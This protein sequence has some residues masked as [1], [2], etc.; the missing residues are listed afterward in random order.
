MPERINVPGIRCIL[1]FILSHG[2]I[3]G[4]RDQDGGTAGLDAVTLVQILCQL[5]GIGIQKVVD[6]FVV[7]GVHLGLL[8]L[9]DG[10]RLVHHRPILCCSAALHVVAI[11][12]LAISDY[13]CCG[14]AWVL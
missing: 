3:A 7:Y 9:G 14:L 5:A 4:A 2:E 10:G 13:S 6:L 8:R 12:K 1:L 11:A